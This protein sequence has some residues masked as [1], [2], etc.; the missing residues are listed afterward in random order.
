MKTTTFNANG[1]FVNFMM[2]ASGNTRNHY[3]SGDWDTCKL[4]KHFA[5]CVVFLGAKVFLGAFVISMS[6]VTGKSIHEIL[7]LFPLVLWY[8]HIV[9]GVLGFFFLILVAA[10][11]IGAVVLISFIGMRWEERTKSRKLNDA[12]KPASPIAVMYNSWKNKIC[13]KVEFK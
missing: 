10:C 11:T 5:W 13:S 3:K 6:Y 12:V 9:A 8:H 7:E 1:K 4:W 2:F